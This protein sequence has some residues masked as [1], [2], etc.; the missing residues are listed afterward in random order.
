MLENSKNETQT[1]DIGLGEQITS[2]ISNI[3]FSKYF[4]VSHRGMIRKSGIFK[5]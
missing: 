5:K 2:T 4:I 1:Q 3:L